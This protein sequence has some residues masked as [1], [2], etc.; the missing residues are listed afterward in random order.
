MFSPGS[1]NSSNHLPSYF[2]KKKQDIISIARSAAKV[3]PLTNFQLFKQ[4]SLNTIPDFVE[5]Q[6]AKEQKDETEL[7]HNFPFLTPLANRKNSIHDKSRL[8]SCTEDDFYL[9]PEP[10]FDIKS[11]MRSMS[12]H[13]RKV[14]PSPM[15]S[16]YNKNICSET[17]LSKFLHSTPK[18]NQN[19]DI[20]NNNR[21]IDKMNP[22]TTSKSGV[23]LRNG[24]VVDSA[25]PLRHC[26]TDGQALIN[27]RNSQ[28]NTQQRY[29]SFAIWVVFECNGDGRNIIALHL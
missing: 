13:E 21:K 28:A 24:D 10:E 27:Q 2:D 9:T 17:L 7:F 18:S 23:V 4:K 3:L 8:S 5:K 29:V 12:Y 1:L 16:H 22:L 26:M 14:F 6:I 20:I 25:Y 11:P 15:P 19:E